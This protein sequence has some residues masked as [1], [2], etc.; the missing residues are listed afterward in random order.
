MTINV[1][2]IFDDEKLTRAYKSAFAGPDGQLVL[3]HLCQVG[4]I[5][6]STRVRGDEVESNMNEGTR[7][8]V[9]SIIKK[10]NFVPV[11]LPSGLEF[12]TKT[13]E[14]EDPLNGSK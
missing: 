8:L 3:Q 7:R 14:E 10:A 2:D 4:F 13:T 1:R 11:G 5:L 6:S 9:L 12:P